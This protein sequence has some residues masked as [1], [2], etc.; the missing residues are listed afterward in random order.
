MKG[1][2]NVEVAGPGIP[3]PLKKSS[4][5]ARSGNVGVATGAPKVGAMKQ[6][7]QPNTRGTNIVSPTKS[8]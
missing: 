8:K 5:G 7:S 2:K 4:G 1:M 6:T 3:A